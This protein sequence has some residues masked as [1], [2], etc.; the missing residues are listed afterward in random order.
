MGLINDHD[1]GI[2][3]PWILKGTQG[4][5]EKVEYIH[6]ERSFGD[7]LPEKKESFVYTYT[8]YILLYTFSMDNDGNG[9]LGPTK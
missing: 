7:A 5:L 6:L 1:F 9:V 4:I 8:Y 2:L 3:K